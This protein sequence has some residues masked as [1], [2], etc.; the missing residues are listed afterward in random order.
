MKE[1]KKIKSLYLLIPQISPL[2]RL[3]PLLTPPMEL[4]LSHSLSYVSSE[5]TKCIQ[6]MDYK[7]LVIEF[8][9]FLVVTKEKIHIGLDNLFLISILCHE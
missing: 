3:A 4:A 5:S 2:L 7:L 9:L 8:I 1:C 6:N